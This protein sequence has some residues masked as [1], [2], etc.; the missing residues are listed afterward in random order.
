MWL[1]NGLLLGV[2]LATLWAL[3]PQRQAWLPWPGMWAPALVLLLTAALQGAGMLRIGATGVLL[4]LVLAGL[5]AT[6]VI[7]AGWITGPDLRR[8]LGR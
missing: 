1:L 7:A 6:F 3:G 4:E 8:A 2:A 5:A